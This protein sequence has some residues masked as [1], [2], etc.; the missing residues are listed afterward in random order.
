VPIVVLGDGGLIDV[1]SEE[2]CRFTKQRHAGL[3]LD[4]HDDAPGP[5][6]ASRSALKART[7]IGPM[8]EDINKKLR[9]NP[10]NIH[11]AHGSDLTA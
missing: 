5:E 9:P 11:G 2:H 10:E 6:P 8:M 4:C 7:N 1:E 3:S